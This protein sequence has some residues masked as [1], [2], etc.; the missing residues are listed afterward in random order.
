MDG[1]I[2]PFSD[3]MQRLHSLGLIYTG[4]PFHLNVMITA[5]YELHLHLKR[6]QEEAAPVRRDTIN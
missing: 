1:A 3:A 2:A 5:V 4:E 6:S